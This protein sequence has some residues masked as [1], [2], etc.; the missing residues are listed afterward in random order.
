MDALKP[1]LM[2][3]EGIVWGPVLLILLLGTGLYLTVGL[4]F[5]SL[6][7]VPRAF[8]LAVL[9]RHTTDTEGEISP[10]QAL[11]TALAATVGTGNIAGVATAIAIGGPGAIFW[12]WMTALVGMA[13]KYSE[14]VLAIRYR[15]I[16][17]KGKYVGG[18]MYYLRNGLGKSL[19]WLGWVFALFTMVAALGIGNMVQSNSVAD[20]LEANFGVPFIATGLVMAGLTFAVI[21][22]G[23]RSIANV[24]ER[25]VPAMAL[26]YVTA[27]IIILALNASGIPGAFAAIFS[28]AFSGTAATG[29][30]V[31]AAVMVAIQMGVARGVFSNES[32]LGSAAIAHAASRTKDPVNQGMIAML[33]TFIDTII[34]CTMTALVILTVSVPAADGVGSVAA[35]ASGKNGAELSSLAFANGIPGGE[36]VITFGLLVF[37]LTTILGWS[38]YGERAAEFLFGVKIITPYRV[39]WVVFVLIGATLELDIAWLIAGI[40][41]GLMAFPNLVGLLALSGTVFALTREHKNK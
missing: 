7:N 32:G 16:D 10:F 21:I 41:N 2:D 30:F 33:G 36:W 9:S 18:P 23:I 24:A 6:R 31:G 37:T 39:V 22:G 29:G 34:I 38:Y 17:E 25:I 19:S 3:L 40:L 11:T 12:M 13:T 35:W 14:A 1:I 8:K 28:G 20:A 26:L 15:E 27:A 4:R 5:F